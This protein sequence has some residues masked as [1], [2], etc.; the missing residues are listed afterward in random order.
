MFVAWS[1]LAAACDPAG[2]PKTV[3]TVSVDGVAV[4]PGR[5]SPLL[6]EVCSGGFTASVRLIQGDRTDTVELTCAEYERELDPFGCGEVRLE[7][8]ASST[9]RT[10][11][12]VTATLDNQHCNGGTFFVEAAFVSEAVPDGD[13]GSTDAAVLDAG[14]TDSA[15]DPVLDAA[16]DAAASSDASTVDAAPHDAA[17]HDASDEDSGAAG[18]SGPDRVTCVCSDDSGEPHAFCADVPV[19]CEPALPVPA[20]TCDEQCPLGTVTSYC[21]PDS[22]M[23]P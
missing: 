4:R 3:V 23:C 7:A 5:A 2:P 12:P 6:A 14:G 1:L 10:F 19:G 21:E 16:L 18:S 11:A 22:S 20:G 13:A 17:S 8:T 9:G 15:V